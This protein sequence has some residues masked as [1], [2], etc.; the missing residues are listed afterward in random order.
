MYSFIEA[1]LRGDDALARTFLAPEYR[2]IV[3]DVRKALGIGPRLRYRTGLQLEE[4]RADQWVFSFASGTSEETRQT[5]LITA[6]R[7]TTDCV[8]SRCVQVTAIDLVR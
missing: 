7:K 1:A 8:P 5:A 3:P 2:I 6:T 4:S